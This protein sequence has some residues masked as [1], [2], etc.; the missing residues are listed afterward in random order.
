MRSVKSVLLLVLVVGGC[1]SDG[2]GPRTII[3]NWVQDFTVPGSF[4]EMN[5]MSTGS[6]VSGTGDWCAEAGPCGT[7]TVAGTING[8]EV[9]LE[10]SFTATSPPQFT[11]SFDDHFDGQLTSF[12][13]LKG[14]IAAVIPGQPPGPVYPTGFHRG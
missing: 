9:H 3:G 1:S 6:I 8:I 4:T 13:A 12:T 10:L 14:S 11:Q 5:L 2:L 7:L